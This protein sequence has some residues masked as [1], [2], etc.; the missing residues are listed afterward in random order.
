MAISTF[1]KNAWVQHYLNDHLTWLQKLQPKYNYPVFINSQ[2]WMLY[3]VLIAKELGKKLDI[4]NHYD[5]IQLKDMSFYACC[6]PMRIEAILLFDENMGYIKSF[7][8]SSLSSSKAFQTSF[9]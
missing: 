1:F 5:E 8:S 3:Y 7:S 4:R 2:V 9:V 6:L